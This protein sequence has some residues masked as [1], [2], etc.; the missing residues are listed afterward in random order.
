[1]RMRGFTLCCAQARW[2]T[3]GKLQKALPVMTALLFDEKP[4]VVRQ[5]LAAL[6]EVVLFRPELSG[7]ISK[8]VQKID[9]KRYKDSMAPLIRKDMDALLAVTGED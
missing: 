9:L 8:A 4:T 3:E 2:D 5:C 7:E 1:M 6:H